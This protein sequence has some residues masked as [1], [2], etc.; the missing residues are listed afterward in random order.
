MTVE[1][2]INLQETS[3]GHFINCG[4]F[5]NKL[6]CDSHT[7]R[8]QTWQLLSPGW[9]ASHPGKLPATWFS[10]TAISLGLPV[11]R[12]SASAY[13]NIKRHIIFKSIQPF[14]LAGHTD[15]T[16]CFASVTSTWQLMVHDHPFFN[17]LATFTPVAQCTDHC[18]TGLCQGTSWL[19]AFNLCAALKYLCSWGWTDGHRRCYMIS[20]VKCLSAHEKIIFWAV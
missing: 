13:M 6:Y 18:N 4:L 19:C 8:K 9:L 2:Y 3:E 7:C 1:C 11:Q 14:F 12:D 10:F 15:I 16:F 20:L 5:L 17:L